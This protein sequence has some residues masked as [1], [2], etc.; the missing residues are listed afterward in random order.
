LNCYKYDSIELIVDGTYLAAPTETADNFAKHFQSLNNNCCSI[1]LPRL[2]HSSEFLSLAPV[3][4]SDVCKATKRLK[5]S[6]SVG[7]YDIPVF[8]IKCFPTIFIPILRHM[9][10]LSLTQQ[11]FPAAW[12][13]AAVVQVFK[14]GNH[15]SVSNYRTNYVIKKFSAEI[16]THRHIVSIGAPSRTVF[17]R[18]TNTKDLEFPRRL[19]EGTEG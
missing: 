9:L 1:N 4:D 2:S 12:K 13:E 14:R 16:F 7:L 19:L 10:N 3:P 17:I 8:N 6:K 15:A 18:G 5:P 11:Y